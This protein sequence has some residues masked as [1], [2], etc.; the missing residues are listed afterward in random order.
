MNEKNKKV[1]VKNM[2][3]IPYV[4]DRDRDYWTEDERRQLKRMF[5][6]GEDLSEIAL[7]LQRTEIAICQQAVALGLYVRKR[8]PGQPKNDSECC[9]CKKCTASLGKCPRRQQCDEMEAG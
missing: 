2:R 5:N 6:D 9:L 8:R 4:Q 7:I 3:K 1:A